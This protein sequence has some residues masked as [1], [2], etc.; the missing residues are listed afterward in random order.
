MTAWGRSCTFGWYSL[1]FD[2]KTMINTKVYAILEYM[3]KLEQNK[4]QKFVLSPYFNKSEELVSL[5]NALLGHINSGSKK[6]MDKELLWKQLVPKKP[7]DDVRFRKFCSDLL[8]L[9]EDF[10]VLEMLESN[11]LHK[12]T[13]LMEAVGKKKMQRLFNSSMRS[14]RRYSDQQQHQSADY[15]YFQ[16]NIEKN[17]YNLT[18][19]DSKRTEKTNIEDIILNLDY[20]YLAEKLRLLCSVISRQS[21]VSHEYKLLFKD[22]IIQYI[23]QHNFE[24]IP[25]IAIYYQVYLTQTNAEQEEHYFRL[26]KYLKEYSLL[27][28]QT[29]ANEMYSFAMN[30]CIRSFN[31]GK[32][33]FLQELFDIYVDLLDKEIIFSEEGELSP[34]HFKNIILTALELGHYDWSENFVISFKDQLPE[35]FRRNAVT[36]NLGQI[37]FYKKEYQKVIE[38]LR[39]VEYEDLA[40]NLDS[41]TMLI[42]T[43]YELDE[44]DPLYSLFESF[45][46]YLNRHKDIA[47][48][49]RK[50]YLNLIRFTKKLTKVRPG[51]RKGLEKIQAELETTDGTVGQKWLR[52]KLAELNG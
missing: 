16:Y 31:K 11:P 6:D 33:Q 30:Y 14:A 42:F 39:N 12:A 10:F 28:P 26:K 19:S 45:R 51:D 29:E 46:V 25:A 18:D 5:A 52:E 38:Q 24:Q 27:F 48:Q 3:S 37:Y 1:T 34:W 22:E 43:Y 13:Y 32:K 20:F 8:K 21:I 4:F 40:Y 23:S 50:R 35:E 2:G 47:P 17:Y 15:F 36:Y 7:Y 49:R 9:A 41:K 44:I